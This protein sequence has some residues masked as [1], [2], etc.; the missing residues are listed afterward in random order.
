MINTY[1]NNLFDLFTLY[2][3]VEN[4]TKDF[5]VKKY[6]DHYKMTFLATGLDKKDIEITYQD[7][8]ITVKSNSEEKPFTKNINHKIRLRNVDQEKIEASLD[9]GILS[10]TAFFAE[11]YKNFKSININ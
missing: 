9:K 4:D 10:I 8:Y 11:N 1:N 3:N 6:K 7:S 2:N 5:I